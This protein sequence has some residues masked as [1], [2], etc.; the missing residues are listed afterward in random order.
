MGMIKHLMVSRVAVATA[1]VVVLA[2]C[3]RAV[4]VGSGTGTGPAAAAANPNALPADITPAM[5][6]MGDSLFNNGSC[7]RCH[8][9][10][11][12]GAQNAPNLTDAQWLQISGTFD[13]IVKV[14]TNG[15]PATAIKDTTHR[16]AMNP[17]GGPMNLTD[18]QVRAVAA[19]VFR[20]SHK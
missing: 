1:A 13:E 7:M 6:A 16:R 15:V 4:N 20:L 18:P 10:A 12:V 2:A 17:R 9:R 19:Y 5:L 11:G 14:I 3:Q 8:G